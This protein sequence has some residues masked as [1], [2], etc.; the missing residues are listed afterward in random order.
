M[1]SP[2]LTLIHL[3]DSISMPKQLLEGLYKMK[4]LITGGA[5]FIGSQLGRFLSGKHEI[6][7]LII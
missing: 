1:I 4:I 6:F 7:S 5:G 2:P 3:C